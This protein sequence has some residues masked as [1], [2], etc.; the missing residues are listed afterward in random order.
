[1]KKFSSS[2][3]QAKEYKVTETEDSYEINS[4]KI[5]VDERLRVLLKEF[6]NLEGTLNSG[7]D[8]IKK[9]ST[10][11]DVVIS[12]DTRQKMQG[13]KKSLVLEAVLLRLKVAK[14]MSV[15]ELYEVVEVAG[16]SNAVADQEDEEVLYENDHVSIEVGLGFEKS[17]ELFDPEF[18]AQ[19]QSDRKT[20]EISWRGGKVSISMS[21]DYSIKASPSDLNHLVLRFTGDFDGG[22]AI[23]KRNVLMIS[24]IAQAFNEKFTKSSVDEHQQEGLGVYSE[25]GSESEWNSGSDYETED[26]LVLDDGHQSYNNFTIDEK[27]EF[28][29]ED[30]PIMKGLYE[31]LS[32]NGSKGELVTSEAEGIMCV[33]CALSIE[34]DIYEAP[35]VDDSGKFKFQVSASEEISYEQMMAVFG[36]LS[37]SLSKVTDSGYASPG[38]VVAPLD[39]EYEGLGSIVGSEQSAAQPAID[40]KSMLDAEIDSARDTDSGHVSPSSV[41]TPLDLEYEGLEDVVSRLGDGSFSS[42]GGPGFTQREA[43]DEIYGNASVV[44]LAGTESGGQR[45]GIESELARRKPV[46]VPRR[47]ETIQLG[48]RSSSKD[49][50]V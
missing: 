9:T 30:R 24:E 45:S 10:G 6:D 17:K 40:L 7:D 23:D 33:V 42:I 38:S 14:D 48:V 28:K 21:G 18:L 25:I 2:G 1:M 4:K 13:R 50:N 47:P 39:P 41:G 15:D 8:A 16:H 34:N 5:K 19:L 12:A 26:E 35:E 37:N 44:M 36:A 49:H 32:K 20:G 46:P 11:F 29:Y 31:A 3:L 27:Y 43:G 22:V